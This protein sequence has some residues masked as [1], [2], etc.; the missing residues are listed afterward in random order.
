M[1]SGSILRGVSPSVRADVCADVANVDGMA[2][3]TCRVCNCLMPCEGL[4][5]R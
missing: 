5:K 4:G 2:G 1:Q 3:V